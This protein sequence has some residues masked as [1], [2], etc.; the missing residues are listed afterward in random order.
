M[1]L[2]QFPITLHRV[3]QHKYFTLPWKFV[4]PRQKCAK[5]PKFPMKFPNNREFVVETGSH[6]TAHTTNYLSL[7]VV[8]GAFASAYQVECNLR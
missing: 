7:A 4:K 5:G 8:F 2:P 1:S 3:F 6:M